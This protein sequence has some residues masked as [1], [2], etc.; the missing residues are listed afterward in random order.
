MTASVAPQP[1]TPVTPPTSAVDPSAPIAYPPRW[2]VQ[3][4]LFQKHQPAFWMFVVL[5]ALTALTVLSE[6]LLYLQHFGEGWIFS[7]VL[8]AIYVIPVL[9]AIYILDPFERE[10]PSL[11]AAA[12]LWGGVVAI[13]LAVVTNTSLLQ[14]LAKLAG[15]AFAQSWGAALVAPPVEE[16]FKYLGVVTMFLIARSEMDDLF[17]GFVYGAVV[18]LGFAAVENV[19]YFIQ[20]IG[21]SGGADELGPVIQMFFVRAILIGAYMHAMWTGLSGVG[22][23]YYVTQRD[24][25]RQK[26]LLVAA[27]LFLLAIAAHLLWNSP[28]LNNL[29][30]DFGGI[31]VFGLIKGLPFLAF[32]IV[33]VYLAQRRERRWFATIT[34]SDVGTDVLSP[35][36]LADLGSVRSR[37]RRFWS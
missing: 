12:F 11:I 21:R 25:P 4:G 31:F 7:V 10:P 8:L 6:Q 22:F 19:Q 1:G 14:A 28:L 36:E 33:L 17:D 18:G 9:L 24:Q 30:T 13:G 15:P 35:T 3:T 27:G 29:L 34:A 26:R 32:L 23:A 5:L 16:T 2:G 20:S 37:R